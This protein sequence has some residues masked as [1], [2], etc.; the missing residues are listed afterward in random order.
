M[1]TKENFTTNFPVCVGYMPDIDDTFFMW[2]R[3]LP[4]GKHNATIYKGAKQFNSSYIPMRKLIDENIDYIYEKILERTLRFCRK[5]WSHHS[6][7]KSAQNLP[8][9]K[10]KRYV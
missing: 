9:Q 5:S 1:D 10:Y 3:S 4:P 7:R 8:W 2:S 6:G